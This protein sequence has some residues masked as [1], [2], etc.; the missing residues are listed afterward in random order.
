MEAQTISFPPAFLLPSVPILV[1][2]YRG[3]RA[4][5]LS[6]SRSFPPSPPAPLP[7]SLSVSSVLPVAVSFW[8]TSFLASFL[9]FSVGSLE[10]LCALRGEHPFYTRAKRESAG[11]RVSARLLFFSSFVVFFSLFLFGASRT[12]THIRVYACF[13]I[14]A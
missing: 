3:A 9:P 14:Y 1:S 5:S 2:I 10:K 12:Y 13:C 11:I 4:P 7:S 8:L 6:F